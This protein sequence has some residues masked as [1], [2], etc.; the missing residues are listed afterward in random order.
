MVSRTALE[1]V[2]Y[3]ITQDAIG[4]QI[5]TPVYRLVYADEISVPR[6]EFFQAGQSGIKPVK[7]FKVRRADYQDEEEIRFPS[8][9]SGK[10]YH[11][12][13]VYPTK[14][15]MTEIYCEVKLGG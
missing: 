11:L 15:E 8:G 1:F 4:Q 2:T 5:K 10:L 13:R 6:T 14:N 3:T 9:A 12:Y 7:A